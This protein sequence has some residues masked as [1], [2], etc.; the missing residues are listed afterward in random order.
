MSN[1]VI[2]FSYFILFYNNYN[3]WKNGIKQIILLC[4]KTW[5]YLQRIQVFLCIQK[6][7]ITAAQGS[8]NEME[9]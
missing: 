9:S 4:Y 7:Y 3:K 8:L 1:N 5:R 6:W 2:F